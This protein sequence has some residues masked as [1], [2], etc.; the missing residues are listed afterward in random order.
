MSNDD[1]IGGVMWLEESALYA[2]PRSRRIS[3]TGPTSH[4]EL[5]TAVALKAASLNS[6]T[7]RNSC[8]EKKGHRTC[9][10]W[11]LRSASSLYK[12]CCS[13]RTSTPPPLSY[14]P[15]PQS[16]LTALTLTIVS[17]KF[18]PLFHRLW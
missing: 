15:L 18:L 13:R 2:D 11:P 12:W 4:L 16:L 6:Q 17:K 3:K 14:R 10:R 5:R 8:S 7:S 1:R 9:A